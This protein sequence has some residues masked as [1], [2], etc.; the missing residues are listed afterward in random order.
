MTEGLQ[1]V[2]PPMVRERPWL[3]EEVKGDLFI[4]NKA[5]GTILL[6]HTRDLE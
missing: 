1:M 5:L 2:L 6:G 4:Y 3:L